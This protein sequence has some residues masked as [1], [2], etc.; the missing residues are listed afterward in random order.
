MVDK[1]LIFVASEFISA[2]IGFAWG[3]GHNSLL[4]IWVGGAFFTF[5]VFAM[6]RWGFDKWKKKKDA[7]KRR[8]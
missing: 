1:W 3:L 4:F 6:T 5:G 7:K 2:A 8:R